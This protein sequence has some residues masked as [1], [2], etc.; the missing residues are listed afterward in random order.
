MKIVLMPRN[1]D[2]LFTHTVARKALGYKPSTD[3]ET[4]LAK[5][6]KWYLEFYG[7]KKKTSW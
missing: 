4:G 5:F 2:V 7:G 1:G 3:L 6:V